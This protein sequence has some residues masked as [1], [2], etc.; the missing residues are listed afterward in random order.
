MSVREVRWQNVH[1]DIVTQIPYIFA[2]YVITKAYKDRAC[3]EMSKCTFC[4]FS[5]I[6]WLLLCRYYRGIV[7]LI[8]KYS[9]SSALLWGT[10]VLSLK[11]KYCY[12][13]CSKNNKKNLW[14]SKAKYSNFYELQST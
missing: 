5:D 2:D 8:F 12:A 14:N 10:I 11:G 7:T 1:C 4:H 9:I 13:G 6:Q 3:T